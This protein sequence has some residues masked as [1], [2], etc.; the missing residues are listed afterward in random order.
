M[1]SNCVFIEEMVY[2]LYF[3][4]L[5]SNKQKEWLYLVLFLIPLEAVKFHSLPQ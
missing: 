1:S 3:F 4:P 5:L 2:K